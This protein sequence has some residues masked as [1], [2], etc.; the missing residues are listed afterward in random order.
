MGSARRSIASYA[1]CMSIVATPAMA[2]SDFWFRQ[3]ASAGIGPCRG[4][5]VERV[6][7]GGS[8]NHGFA[9]VV[10]ACMTSA[11]K[12]DWVMVGG[13][14]CGDPGKPGRCDGK[15][16]SRAAMA[17]IQA[18]AAYAER[19]L[20]S[21]RLPRA[22]IGRGCTLAPSERDGHWSCDTKETL[23]EFEHSAAPA[24]FTSLEGRTEVSVFG[25]S[26]ELPEEIRQKASS[27]T[28]PARTA[29]APAKAAE[30]P[31]EPDYPHWMGSG[32]HAAYGLPETDAEA[33]LN[34]VAPGK[35]ELWV[36]DPG[37]GPRPFR[38]YEAEIKGLGLTERAPFRVH[39]TGD[40]DSLVLSIPVDG[41]ALASL[42]GGNGF[43][44][45]IPTGETVAVPG[46]SAG[47]AAASLK[48]ACGV[49]RRQAL[50]IEGPIPTMRMP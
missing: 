50:P 11:S 2:T 21:I 13:A 10:A 39:D 28:Q 45:R 37:K 41:L 27:A 26:V 49:P 15:G 5:V 36:F 14:E 1:L 48:A 29:A 3:P 16:P 33:A 6:G 12:A 35:V 42:S 23:T 25:K 46:A 30:P 9:T 24:R 47:K 18:I 34:C 40:G 32:K 7:E 22:T 4:A 44:I 43:V 20:R 17:R 38:S 19:S 31:P 8:V